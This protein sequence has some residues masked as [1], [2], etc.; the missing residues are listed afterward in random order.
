MKQLMLIFLL[1]PILSFANADA[2]DFDNYV[3]EEG[4]AYEVCTDGGRWQCF[5]Q[6]RQELALQ[7]AQTNR[8]MGQLNPYNKSALLVAHKSWEQFIQDDCEY[9]STFSPD[10][11]GSGYGNMYAE[12]MYKHHVSRLKELQKT[13]TWLRSLKK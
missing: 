2:Y 4:D 1:L 12:C 3:Y 8:R 13:E 10:T 7:I 5:D 11:L 9:H 6:K